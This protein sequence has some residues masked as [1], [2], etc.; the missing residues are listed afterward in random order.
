[1]N[2]KYVV[3]GFAVIVLLAGAAFMAGRL[4][5][6][7]AQ[8]ESGPE[9]IM[10]LDGEVMSGGGPMIGGQ[11]AGMQ[12]ATMV[13]IESA[14]ELPERPQDVMGT[15]E[16]VADNSIFVNASSGLETMFMMDENGNIETDSNSPKNE[17]EI[18]ITQDTEI[19]QEKMEMIDM[20]DPNA[21]ADMPETIKQKVELI[22]MEEI[23]DNGLISA[24]GQKRGERLIAEVVLYMGF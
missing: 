13:E 6:Q 14:P 1:M 15:I 21:M 19:Y 12:D 17:V 2:K 16:K 20:S 23:G 4:L 24:W 8:A 3:I 18:V 10:G 7:S 9:M 22:T 5:P 11:G